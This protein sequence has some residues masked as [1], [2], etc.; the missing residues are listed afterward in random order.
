[1]PYNGYTMNC[2]VKNYLH[3]DDK[4][5]H[6]I[7]RTTPNLNVLPLG[8]DVTEH[9]FNIAS[10]YCDSEGGCHGP[11]HTERVHNTALYIGQDMQADLK[12]LSA[13]AL[14]HDIGR[15]YEI[16]QRGKICH[17]VIGADLA[18]K[19]LTSLH[20]TQDMTEA[21]AQC[22]ASHRYRSGPPPQ[23]IEAK[24]LFDA[25]KL[26]SIGAIGIGRAFLFAGEI[27]AKLHN[28]EGNIEKTNS[29]TID[30]T[31]YREFRVKMCKIRERMLTKVGRRLADERHAFMELYFK[32]LDCEIGNNQKLPHTNSHEHR[33]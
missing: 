12:I 24:I 11:D 17:A 20:M 33:D 23:S 22:I 1:M 32:R 6:S 18:K 27:G 13:A 4:F 2:L 10:Q 7:E 30:D 19:I 3:F 8:T 5:L 28:G 25:D 21:V 29:Y 14:L 31:A 15:R 16:N 9:L 26:D